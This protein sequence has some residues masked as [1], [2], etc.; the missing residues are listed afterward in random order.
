MK[1]Q[2]CLLNELNQNSK[3]ANR[4]L[5]EDKPATNII[6]ALKNTIKTEKETEPLKKKK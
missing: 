6:S 5:D 3:I 2:Q 1:Y 4:I